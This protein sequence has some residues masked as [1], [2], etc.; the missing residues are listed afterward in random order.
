MPRNAE[1][2]YSLDDT[3]LRVW[4]P[5]GSAVADL[6]GPQIRW[7]AFDYGRVGL[8]R[9]GQKAAALHDS[10]GNEVATLTHSATV[11]G[12]W[13]GGRGRLVVTWAGRTVRLWDESGKP[14]ATISHPRDVLLAYP[15]LD[16]GKVITVTSRRARVHDAGGRALAEWELPDMVAGVRW[17]TG[18]DRLL[19]RSANKVARLWDANGR[20]L[21]VL[22][23]HSSQLT[24]ARFSRDGDL[25]VTT[26][27]DGRAILW[28]AVGEPL[29]VLQHAFSVRGAEFLA[30]GRHFVTYGRNEA[31]L[32]NRRG[33]LVAKLRGH[34]KRV[35][36]V[37]Y[38]GQG[39]RVVTCADDGTVRLWPVVLADAL[40]LAT[41]HAGR[42]LTAGERLRYAGLL[43]K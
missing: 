25:I 13:I 37:G 31:W 43:A 30:H 2:V 3:S 24:E 15:R 21:R 20:Q 17:A 32:W 33:F 12:I 8:V 7:W 11:L 6:A 26:S 19:L 18:T 38:S 27:L 41:R 28:N 22:D 35:N 36:G 10:S 9:H 39:D 23:L 40:A 29:R 5:D 4:T 34:G 16:G 42:E 1:R 14:L